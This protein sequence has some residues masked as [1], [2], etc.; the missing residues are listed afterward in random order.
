MSEPLPNTL[1][2]DAP[3]KV[4]LFLRVLGRRR[5]GYHELQTLV[6]PLSWGDRVRVHAFSD[7]GQFS[8]LSLSLRIQGA[9]EAVRGIPLDESNLALRAAIELAEVAGAR[10]FAEIVLDKRVP[11]A[12]GMG[13][14]SADAAATLRALNSLWGTALDE[15]ELAEVAGR[16]GSDVPAL[17][18]GGG[19]LATGRGETVRRFDVGPLRWSLLT[20]PFGVRTQD[21]FRWWDDDGGGTGPD[22]RPLLAA[23]RSG[24]LLQVAG[25]M[26]NDLED[27]VTRRHPE[28]G[29]AK[30]RL[31]ASGAAGAVMCGSGPTIAA[32]VAGERSLRSV[33]PDEVPSR[34]IEAHSL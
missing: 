29:K 11:A 32:L 12:A 4:N 34:L 26:Y 6:L 21:A 1:V 8:T 14:G 2:V 24:D 23:A 27:P 18:A 30:E 33:A 10:G 9:E 7:P 3:A 13:G 17:L 22:P 16:V 28:I 25:L 19:A 15:Q 5:D 20:F 31:L